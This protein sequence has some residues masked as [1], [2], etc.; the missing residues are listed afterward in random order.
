MDEGF[1]RRRQAVARLVLSA[2]VI[3]AVWWVLPDA[4]SAGEHVDFVAGID[5]LPL[6]QGL[7]E[8]PEAGVVFDKPS[9][10]IVEA[11][12]EGA[13]ARAG[14]AAFYA[15]TLPQLGWEAR[16]GAQFVREGE[17]LQLDYLGT[18]GELIVR[19]TL[20]PE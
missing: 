3:V 19:F 15:R 18:D 13:V 17:R 16:G 14:V 11:Y 4:V 1:L 8:V 20:Q 9:G 5:D 10:R 2:L 12:A 6:M 7:A